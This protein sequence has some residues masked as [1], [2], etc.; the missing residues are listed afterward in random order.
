MGE[1]GEHLFIQEFVSQAAIEAFDEGV[2]HWLARGDV[3][4]WHAIVV[5]PFEHGPAGQLGAVIADDR[6]RSAMKNN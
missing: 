1:A 3:V 2:L 5:L 4:P 6:P